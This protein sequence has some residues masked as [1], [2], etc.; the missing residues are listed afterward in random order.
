MKSILTNLMVVVALSFMFACG[1]KSSTE[2][3]NETRKSGN[4]PELTKRLKKEHDLMTREHE[5]MEKEHRALVKEFADMDKKYEAAHGGKRDKI[6]ED[7]AKD[8][9]KLLDDHTKLINDHM[10]LIKQHDDA[11]IKQGNKGMT[12]AEFRKIHHA[13]KEKHH[14][15]KENH[16]KM[17]MTH[18]LFETDFDLLMGKYDS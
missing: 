1:G 11:T 4:S 10:V 6:Y 5:F 2:I 15:M 12:D 14:D 3:A 16:M 18:D 7:A 8:H 9:K 17:K 13:L